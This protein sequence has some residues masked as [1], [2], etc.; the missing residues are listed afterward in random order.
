[1]CYILWVC[2]CSLRYPTCYVHAQYCHLCPA[3]LCNIFFTLSQKGHIFHGK[4]IEYEM[5]VL[6]LSTIFARNIS[7]SKKNWVRYDQ[8]CI[9]FF[10][11][12]TRY[13][14]HIVM[15]LEFSRHIFWKY[16]N[17]KFRENLPRG[18]RGVLCELTHGRTADRHN[19]ANSRF[20]QFCE[21][22]S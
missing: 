8:K 2:F 6:I 21:R 17:I 18:S 10:M 4:V 7:Y 22:D 11:G 1:M 16:S 5:C 15:K 14:C 3:W 13:S 12:S 9:L 19:Q 20:S